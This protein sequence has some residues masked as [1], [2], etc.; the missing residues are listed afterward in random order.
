MQVFIISSVWILNSYAAKISKWPKIYQ[1]EKTIET[2][3]ETAVQT[4]F[5]DSDHKIRDGFRVTRNI[6]N[7]KHLNRAIVPMIASRIKQQN[8]HDERKLLKPISLE[9]KILYKCMRSMLGRILR[10]TICKRQAEISV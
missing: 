3:I 5:F 4:D 6:W 9:G 2:S 7:N 8:H 1:E 10:H